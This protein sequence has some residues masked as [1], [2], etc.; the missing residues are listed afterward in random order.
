MS[1]EKF[2]SVL[3]LFQSGSA[4]RCKDVVQA[5]ESLGF[6]VRD[7]KRG[8]HKIFV[9]DRLQDFY[10]GSFNCDHGK[11]P[12]IKPGYIRNIRKILEQYSEELSQ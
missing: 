12:Q 3:S 8:G 1:R 2:Q 5:L 9:H 7:G 10:S 6:E 11:N 4:L